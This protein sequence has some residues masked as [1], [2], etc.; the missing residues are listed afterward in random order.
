MAGVSNAG[1]Y[2][3]QQFTL[4]TKTIIFIIFFNVFK[5][6]TLWD[7]LNQWTTESCSELLYDAF[8]L[9]FDFMYISE[10]HVFV[11]YRCRACSHSLMQNKKKRAVTLRETLWWAFWGSAV[12]ASSTCPPASVSR[13]ME[14]ETWRGQQVPHNLKHF[15]PSEIIIFPKDG[16]VDV[17]SGKLRM[18]LILFYFIIYFEP[19]VGY[20]WGSC[21]PVAVSQTDQPPLT[22]LQ[23]DR[24]PPASSGLPVETRN[25]SGGELAAGSAGPGSDPGNKRRWNIM[26]FLF[27]CG[28]SSYK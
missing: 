27:S 17:F 4:C 26:N 7:I 18:Q 3:Y 10:R 25:C 16:T 15:R 5:L 9:V 22:H 12:G 6:W 21:S 28:D 23:P 1:I 13:L 20:I 2:N 24:R 11:K 14:R 8:Q 19:P